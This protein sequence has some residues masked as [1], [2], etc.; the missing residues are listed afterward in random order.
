MSYN[1]C[2]CSFGVLVLF[3]FV[4]FFLIAL[5]LIWLRVYGFG[6][7]VV[8]RLAVYLCFSYCVCYGLL[9]MLLYFGYCLVCVRLLVCGFRSVV[10]Y[11][12]VTLLLRLC[13]CF[14]LFML[15]GLNC[16]RL[17]VVLLVEWFFAVDLQL[18]VAGLLLIAEVASDL[19]YLRVCLLCMFGLYFV[20]CQNCV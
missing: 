4:C 7:L 17:W 20:C 11:Y 5:T 10:F 1:D 15:D 3:V 13:C 8:A 2:S 19:T 6:C 18:F 12:L 9:V 14:G 16:F